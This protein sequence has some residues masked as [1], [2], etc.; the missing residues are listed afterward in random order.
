[1]RRLMNRLEPVGPPASYQ[2]YEIRSRPD[3]LVR[4]ACEQAGCLAYRYGWDTTVDESIDLGRRQA[5]YIRQKSG[6]TFRELRDGGL[7]VF[8]FDSG[9]RCFAEHKTRPEVFRVVGGDHRGNPLGLR[10]V[11][12]KRPEDWLEDFGE[13][14][15][16]LVEQ[17]QK[18]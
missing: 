6:R 8:R 17:R 14:Q 3:R 16:R 9:Q 18:G 2:T 15:L 5:A 10:P 13:H 11:R 1:M 12:H 7:T 4:T